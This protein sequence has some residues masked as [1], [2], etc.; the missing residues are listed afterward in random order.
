MS[1]QRDNSPRGNLPISLDG[2]L[3]LA[4]ADDDS[5]PRSWPSQ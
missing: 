2:A 5:A 4:N 1:E 3:R